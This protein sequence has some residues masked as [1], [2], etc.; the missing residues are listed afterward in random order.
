LYFLCGYAFFFFTAEQ[1]PEEYTLSAAEKS[2]EILCGYV[3]LPQS[4]SR[5]NL[6]IFR[7]K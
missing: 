4:N 5:R 2:F 6:G 1:Q 7:F 3:F